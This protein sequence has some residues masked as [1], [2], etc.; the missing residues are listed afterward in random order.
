M[1]TK[2]KK[3]YLVTYTDGSI[4]AENATGI[5]GV[6]KEKFKEGVSFME[7]EATP[8]KDDILHF[9]SLG[10]SSV[11][12]SADE[13]Q[14]ISILEGVMAVEEDVEMFALKSQEEHEQQFMELFTDLDKEVEYHETEQ[15]HD[16]TGA[17]DQALIDLFGAFLKLRGKTALI[18]KDSFI[19][20]ALP[21]P[22]TRLQPVPWNISM[23]KAPL[24]WRRG[25]NGRGVKVAILDTG[26]AKHR[27]LTISGGTC[28]VQNQSSYNDIHGHGTHCAGVVAAR[29]NSTG[30]VGVAPNAKLYAVKV[31]NDQGS[32][33][34]SWIIAGLEWCV[35][36]KIDVASM[37]LGGT[38]YPMAA[39]AS[40]IK[41][42][43]NNG[44]VVV[45]ASGNYYGTSFPWVCAPANSI[46]P[47]QP[48]ASPIAVGAIDNRKQIAGFS[49]RGG[50][51]EPWNQV[52]SV[53]PGV[54]IKSTWPG[55]EYRTLHGTSMA[56]PHVAGLAALIAQRYPDL[57][58]TN[59][60]R[61]IATTC[62]DL[63]NHGLDVTYGFGLINCD[64]ATC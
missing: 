46:L 55:N 34:T 7:T 9:E 38:S 39:Y 29:N 15:N 20:P 31:L 33:M 12:L 35:K 64:L 63:G 30:V 48:N 45:I 62:T 21:E 3:R 26:I 44:V 41:R 8:S 18:D 37:S 14:K 17:Y 32:G 57:S 50:K 27:D 42:C 61:R 58:A 54:S 53:A 51:F 40:A 28:F 11:E 2:E 25:I 60:K 36:N 56:C 24:A 23:V 59:V 43:Q 6:K 1:T 4:S 19:L 13:V 10:I 5:L 22:K 52:F 49:S 47:G 16:F